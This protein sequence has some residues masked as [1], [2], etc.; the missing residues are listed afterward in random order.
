MN[1]EQ[2]PSA[3]NTWKNKSCSLEP[4]GMNYK[5]IGGQVS[6]HEN[7]LLCLFKEI[8]LYFSLFLMSSCQINVLVC[9][10][11]SQGKT[12][13]LCLTHYSSFNKYSLIQ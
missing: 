2:N 9:F 10:S 12:K 4:S 11:F 8:I 5:F 3:F 1:H 7:I 6:R 13:V